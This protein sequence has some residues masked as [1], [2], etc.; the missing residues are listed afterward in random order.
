MFNSRELFEP[1]FYWYYAANG[2]P[3]VLVEVHGEGPDALT[4]RL[5]G[6]AGEEDLRTLPGSFHGPI[7]PP[8]KP[9]AR[10]Q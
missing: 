8:V 1:G 6:R 5:P 2:A 9:R 10:R 4:V 7:P 3:P